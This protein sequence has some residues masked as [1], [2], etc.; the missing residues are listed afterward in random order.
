M[1]QGRGI[2]VR[3]CVVAV[4]LPRPPFCF[5]NAVVVA[6]FF[7]SNLKFMVGSSA[8]V[9]FS[10]LKQIRLQHSLLLSHLDYERDL[11]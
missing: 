7:F 3:C 9:A 1:G 4:G 6:A 5:L 10:V 8:A 11:S 2:T